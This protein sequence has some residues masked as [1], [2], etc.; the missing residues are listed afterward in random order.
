M[1]HWLVM[2]APAIINVREFF[3]GDFCVNFCVLC[4]VN[5][6]DG[7]RIVTRDPNGTGWT[8]AAFSEGLDATSSLIVIL[9]LSLF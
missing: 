1:V 9:E 7:M 5:Y 3:C 2:V 6:C 4:I 8:L